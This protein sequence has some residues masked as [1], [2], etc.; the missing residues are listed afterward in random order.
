MEWVL[1]SFEELSALELHDILRAR[2]DVFVVEQ[3]CAYHEVDGY[4]PE[5]WHLQ[6]KI[7]GKL[8]AYARLMKAGTKYNKA[9]IGRIIVIEEF[10]NRQ[11]GRALVE[12]SID[13]M[14]DWGTG[15]IMLQGQTYLR[16][17]YGS[18][19][20]EEISAEYLD[21]GIPHVDML[22]TIDTKEKS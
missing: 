9:S 14:K 10:R 20:F 5:S 21:D 8:A 15:E 2:V 3:D 13:V 11:I 12:K 18:F 7:D 1:K 16:T 17:F 19:G 22:L 6:L 4:D